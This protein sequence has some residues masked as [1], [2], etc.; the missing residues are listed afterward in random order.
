MGSPKTGPQRV[1]SKAQQRFA[2]PLQKL[3]LTH[4]PV[5]ETQTR[6]CSLR[7]HKLWRLQCGWRPM[8]V[9]GESA[10]VQTSSKAMPRGPALPFPQPPGR[11][12]V[13]GH[14]DPATETKMDTDHGQGAQTHPHHGP[15]RVG[16]FLSGSSSQGSA[17]SPPLPGL[18]PQPLPPLTC[19]EQSWPVRG[20]S[21]KSVE[22]LRQ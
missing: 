7:N 8:E 6:H 18:S 19:G 20:T 14:L 17:S 1:T 22:R 5:A 4:T 16:S 12:H 9:C 10:G 13:S 2:S 3:S 11:L 21:E 15:R